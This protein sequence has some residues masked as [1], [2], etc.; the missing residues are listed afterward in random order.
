MFFLKNRWAQAREIEEGDVLKEAER[1]EIKV[2]KIGKTTRI[3][4]QIGEIVFDK[5]NP[6]GVP[7]AE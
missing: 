6:E 4:V 2:T 1:D 7:F 5:L 3:T